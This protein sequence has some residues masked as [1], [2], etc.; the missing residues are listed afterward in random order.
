M[1]ESSQDLL[2]W[3]GSLGWNHDSGMWRR[4]SVY[5]P[6]FGRAGHPRFILPQDDASV[7]FP[8]H[9]GR[10]RLAGHHRNY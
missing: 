10:E 2:P 5:R 8:G 6:D 3:G 1:K 9:A 4:S 7:S